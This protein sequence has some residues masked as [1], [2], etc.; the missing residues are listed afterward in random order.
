[1]NDIEKKIREEIE[2]WKEPQ[3][4]FPWFA[5]SQS[6]LIDAIEKYWRSEFIRSSKEKSGW[7]KLFYNIIQNPT[8]VFAKQMDIDTKNVKVKPERGRSYWPAWFF[9]RELDIWLKEK[10]IPKLLNDMI[11]SLAKYGHVVL[12]KVNND[13]EMVPVSNIIIDPTVESM[14]NNPRIE[15]HEMTPS[16]LDAKKKRW[17]GD[18]IDDILDKSPDKNERYVI[19][20]RFD[21]MV[22]GDNY[23]IVHLAGEQ[24]ANVLKTGRLDDPYR[25]HKLGAIPGRWMGQ[26]VPERLFPNQIAE[27]MTKNMFHK[28][29]VYTSK[30]LW[31]TQSD[32][33]TRNLLTNVEDGRLITSFAPIEPIP[34]EERNLHAYRYAHDIWRQN[35]R[36]RTFSF[37]PMQGQRAPAGTPLGSSI[38]QSRMA[39]GFF[40]LK[41]EELGIFLKEIIRRDIIPEFEDNKGSEHIVNLLNLAEDDADLEKL[42]QLLLK[43]RVSKKM[44]AKQLS[45]GRFPTQKDRGFFEALERGKLQDPRYRDRRIPDG[46]YDNL[47]YKIDI[48]ITDEQIDAA[49]RA[50]TLQVALQALSSNPAIMKDPRLKTVFMKLLENSGIN[51]SELNL[52]ID[53]RAPEPAELETLSKMKGGSISAPRQGGGKTESVRRNITV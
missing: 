49:G 15:I 44:V 51:P 40:D 8:L 25:E 22:A 6:S 17:D 26:G 10:N 37:S 14:E 48:T 7:R 33:P 39:G 32:I 35:T 4:G 23:H 16:E 9:Q 30:H 38:L 31:Q 47:E 2:K 27:N 36:E 45:T 50:A 41:R 52:D 19:Y 1:M 29:L 21:P 5:T 18:A 24:G 3:E 11:F 34:M 53:S 28:G 20:E 43:E 42:D 12:K 13:L 46:Y